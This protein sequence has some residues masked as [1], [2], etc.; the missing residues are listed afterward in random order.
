MKPHA[1]TTKGRGWHRGLYQGL[2][3]ASAQ[4]LKWGC[5]S[6]GEHSP[7]KFEALRSPT[8]LQTGT[9][10]D[11][12]MSAEFRLDPGHGMRE[13]SLSRPLR[14]GCPFLSLRLMWHVGVI[15]KTHTETF[16]RK[17][18]ALAGVPRA[19]IKTVAKSSLG[20]KECI[21]ADTTQVPPGMT[22][23]RN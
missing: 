13:M 18:L 9:D 14:P 11:R 3:G 15:T 1:G 5:S 20:K 23:G 8:A 12:S 19:V 22:Q 6:L 17:P 21:S 7:P 2:Q 4:R 16:S 10:S